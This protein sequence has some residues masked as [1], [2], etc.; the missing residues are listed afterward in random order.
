MID[1]YIILNRKPNLIMQVFILNIFLLTGF[2][3]WCINTLPYQFYFQIHSQ[4]F[5]KNSYYY[6]KVLIPAKEV[7]EITKQNT[8]W[9]N[10]KKYNYKIIKES[11]N[12]TYKHEKNYLTLYLKIENLEEEYKKNGYHINIKI[13]RMR[14]NTIAKNIK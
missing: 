3:I 4:I 14:R 10:N 8:L 13:K 5:N 12:I 11:N 1:T 2:V 9:I 7:N 6:L